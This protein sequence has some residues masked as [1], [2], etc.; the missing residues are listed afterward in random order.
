V[1]ILDALPDWLVEQRRRLSSKNAP[2][3]AIQ[4]AL[5]RWALMRYVSTTM[6]PTASAARH[7]RHPQELPVPRRRG[8]RGARR[9][10]LDTVLESA[11][12]GGVDPEAYLADVIDRIAI[13]RPISRPAELLPWNWQRQPARMAP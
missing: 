10:S 9:N 7:C 5:I 4:Y 12:L 1:S 13:G 8:G 2:S 11:K 3:R 6:P